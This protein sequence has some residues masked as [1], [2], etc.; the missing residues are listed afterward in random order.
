[1]TDPS[2]SDQLTPSGN[3]CR[4]GHCIAAAP[5]C[6]TSPTAQS[7]STQTTSEATITTGAAQMTMDEAVEKKGGEDS[8]EPQCQGEVEESVEVCRLLVPG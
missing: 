3:D 8:R 4:E 7:T 1:M 6:D 5:L 2:D